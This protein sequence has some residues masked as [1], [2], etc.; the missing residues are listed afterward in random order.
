MY[1]HAHAIAPIA[2]YKCG[3]LLL[4]LLLPLLSPLRLVLLLYTYGSR[5]C[6]LRRYYYDYVYDRRYYHCYYC[7]SLCQF[8]YTHEARPCRL[9]SL[10]IHYTLM[11]LGTA[12][13]AD[14]TTLRVRPTLLPLL[15]L[16]LPVPIRL[17]S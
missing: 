14:T 1:T 2:P 12:G 9:R 6:R 4:L 7:C 13:F 8:D 16:L 10:S 17:H 3:V 15:L 11:G 5:H